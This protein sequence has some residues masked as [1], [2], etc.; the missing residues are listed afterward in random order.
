MTDS[1]DAPASADGAGHQPVAAQEVPVGAAAQTSGD[2][3]EVPV[4]AAFAGG[5]LV[6]MFLRRL[7]R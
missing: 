6:A 1:L 5:F 4:V 3:P 7:A 2:R